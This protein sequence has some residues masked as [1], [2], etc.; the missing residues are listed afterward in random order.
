[1]ATGAL[2]WPNVNFTLAGDGNFV[3][4]WHE[5]FTFNVATTAMR[6][7]FLSVGYPNTDSN[8]GSIAFTGGQTGQVVALVKM[9]F[10]RI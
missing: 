4:G 3:E 1:M 2:H 7:F 10:P 6:S 5:N 9:E 8:P